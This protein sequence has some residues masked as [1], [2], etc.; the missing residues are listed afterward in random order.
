MN[1]R[2]QP[3]GRRSN[4]PSSGDAASHLRRWA[5]RVEER[6]QQAREQGEFDNLEGSGKPLHI[7]ENVHAGDK[8]LAYSLLKSNHL[9]P[10]EIERRKE[11][12]AELE[13]AESMLKPL[14]HQHETLRFR[15]GSPFASERRAY[16]ILRD[17][18]LVRYRDTLRAINSKILSLNIIAPAPLHLRMIDVDARLREF[19]AE[20]PLLDA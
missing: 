11:V 1:S 14:R 13:R 2:Q 19:E 16:N 10:P 17:K 8:A 5:D 12:D 9:A 3:D 15:L 18:T 7:E 20:F 4:V 6:I